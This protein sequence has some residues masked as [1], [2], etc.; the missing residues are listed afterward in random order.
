VLK[1]PLLKTSKYDTVKN[2]VGQLYMDVNHPTLTLLDKGIDESGGHA[3]YNTLQQI[4]THSKDQVR[5]D[6]IDCSI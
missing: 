6:Q 2:G 3:V 5:L 1:T 4:Y